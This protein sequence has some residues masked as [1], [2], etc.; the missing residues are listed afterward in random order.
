MTEHA[1]HPDPLARTVAAQVREMHARLQQLDMLTPPPEVPTV[2]EA[3]ATRA[4]AHLG[5]ALGGVVQALNTAAQGSP[6]AHYATALLYA[7]MV[8]AEL[9]H[10]EP[11]PIARLTAL[12]VWAA[13]FRREVMHAPSAEALDALDGEPLAAVRIL[14]ALDARERGAVMG[15]GAVLQGASWAASDP[16]ATLEGLTAH[17]MAAAQVLAMLDDLP[18]P[19]SAAQA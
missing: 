11:R 1:A 16:A 17:L 4:A 10:I 14:R 8:A 12:S 7:G 18:R 15:A 13:E 5:A 19:P 2:S 3:Q 6:L 9:H